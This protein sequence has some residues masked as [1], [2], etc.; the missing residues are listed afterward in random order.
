MRAY[1]SGFM[2]TNADG[3]RYVY[4]LTAL[5]C[6]AGTVLPLMLNNRAVGGGD[7]QSA[8][9]STAGQSGVKYGS[10]LNNI[11]LLIRVVGKVTAVGADYFYVDDGS[12]F[13]D[14]SGFEGIK[15]LG[16]VPD[17]SPVGRFVLVTGAS[18]CFK[19]G[20]EIYRQVRATEVVVID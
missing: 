3:E 8:P 1:V 17:P 18:S 4:A 6:G 13:C 16:A 15:V 12:R 5:R 14:D 7:W 11:G 9:P 10:G 20:S 19:S 2:S